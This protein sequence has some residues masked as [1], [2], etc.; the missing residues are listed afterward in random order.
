[1]L[2]V[3]LLHL[4]AGRAAFAPQRYHVLLVGVPRV[5]VEA[6]VRSAKAVFPTLPGVEKDLQKL[7]TVLEDRWGVP[8]QAVTIDT[9]PNDTTKAEILRLI[10]SKLVEPCQRGDI[11][12][13]GYS[14]HCYQA[15]SD[16]GL[17][18]EGALGVADA[19]DLD[20]R[21]RSRTCEKR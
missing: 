19:A 5:G 14:G 3:L 6:P 17:G 10:K 9:L 8:K 4:I 2:G 21:F 13:F 12:W 20:P 1:M 7:A 16:D 18:L 15:P 11:V